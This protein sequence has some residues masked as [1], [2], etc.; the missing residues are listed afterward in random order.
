MLLMGLAT[1]VRVPPLEETS[2]VQKV[3]C[4]RMLSGEHDLMSSHDGCVK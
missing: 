3:R 4:V 2:F 1:G